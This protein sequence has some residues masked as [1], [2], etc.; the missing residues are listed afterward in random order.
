MTNFDLFV[1]L[2]LSDVGGEV[3]KV[4]RWSENTTHTGELD[5]GGHNF[6]EHHLS[7]IFL[8]VESYCILSAF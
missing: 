1:H 3:V 7:S 2:Y 8:K 5:E 4:E 6:I